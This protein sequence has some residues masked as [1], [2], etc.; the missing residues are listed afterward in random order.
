MYAVFE[1]R[2]APQGAVTSPGLMLQE[3]QRL[4]E[5]LAKLVRQ[6]QGVFDLEISQYYLQMMSATG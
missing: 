3:K 5:R 2:M 1:G 6:C 4:Y